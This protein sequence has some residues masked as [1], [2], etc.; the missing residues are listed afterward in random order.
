MDKPVD[1]RSDTF[2]LPDSGM[3][4]AIH[5]AEVGNSAYGEDPSVNLLEETIA[6]YFGME[7]GIFLPS[8]TMAGQIGFKVHTRPGDVIIIENYGHGYY[9]E[10]GSMGLISGILPR[11]VEGDKGIMNPTRVRSVI[12]HLE[13]QRGRARLLVLENASNFGGGTVYPLDTLRHFFDLCREE[14]MPLQIDGARIWN[15]VIATGAEPRSLSPPGGSM[16]VCFSKGLGAPMGAMLLGERGFIDEARGVQSMLGGCM[17]Q[18]GFMAAAALY[19]FQHNLTR[20]EEDHANARAI[21]NAIADNPALVVD[22]ESVETNMVYFEVKAGA[23]RASWLVQRLEEA[24]V[25]CW[26]IGKLVRLV[27]SLNVDR[28]DCDFAAQQINRLSLQ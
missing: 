2:T 26:A 21:A 15:A 18:V 6:D 3:R 8:A 27:T 24:G 1:L 23:E 17:R 11:L 25:K 14:K 13:Q 9:F 4:K 19:G 12:E 22:P 7:Y 28:H 5:A 10:H 16:S 20:L